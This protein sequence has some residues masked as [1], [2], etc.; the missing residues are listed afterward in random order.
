MSFRIVIPD[1]VTGGFYYNFKIFSMRLAIGLMAHSLQCDQVWI[2]LLRIGKKRIGYRTHGDAS[3]NLLT[4]G[5]AGF[6]WPWQNR[7]VSGRG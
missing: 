1:S 3:P 2:F 4:Y 7:T 5:D 6:H